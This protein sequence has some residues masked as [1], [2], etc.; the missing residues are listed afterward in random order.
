MEDFETIWRR[1]ADRHGGEAALKKR[2]T[3]VKS[4]RQ[5]MAI[6][7][8]RWLAE[9]TKRVFQAGFVWKVVEAKWP[10][11]EEAFKGFEPRRVAAFSED[12]ID[13]LLKDTRIIRNG[14]KIISAQANALFICDLAR[15]HGSAARF[16][17]EWP[18][19]NFI[20]LVEVLK[21]RGSRL[22]G[23]TGQI[24]MRFMGK[25]AFLLRPDVNA[26]LIRAGVV[27][28]PPTSKKDLAA[29]QTAFN[30]WSR[31]SGRGLTHISQTLALSI[32]G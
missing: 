20:G 6:T 28:K 3:K 2:L 11:F 14:Q 29:V 4:K 27:D 25:E 31:Q 12:D 16:F 5:L 17:A 9:M 24:V 32:D 10:G 15:E 8:D 13:A 18:D 22:G 1:A 30:D 21:K 19:D 23:A 7:D 26:A